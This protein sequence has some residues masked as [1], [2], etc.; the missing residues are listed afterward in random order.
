MQQNKNQ[1]AIILNFESGQTDCLDLC[2]I[3][4]DMD[5]EEYI[6]TILDYSL[7]NCEWLI[8]DNYKINYLNL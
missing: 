6:E 4:Q 8:T 1:Y 3:P 7:S 5:T 2:N